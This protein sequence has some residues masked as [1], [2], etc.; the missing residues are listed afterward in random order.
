MQDQAYRAEHF[1]HANE[2]QEQARQMDI[3]R[4]PLNRY[5]Q[6]HSTGEQKEERDQP[7]NLGSK[8]RTSSSTSN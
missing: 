5:D 2:S 6:L 3:L 1:R 7:L 4:H 8:A